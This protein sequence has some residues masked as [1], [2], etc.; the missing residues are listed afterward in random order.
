MTTLTDTIRHAQAEERTRMAALDMLEYAKSARDRADSLEGANEYQR[1]VQFAEHRL[2]QLIATAFE[3][4]APPEF[5][6]DQRGNLF[7]VMVLALILAG[8]A[9]TT[10]WVL[11]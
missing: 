7:G 6:P 4:L 1:H 11:L 2:R 5:K 3:P 9:A 10:L 8:I